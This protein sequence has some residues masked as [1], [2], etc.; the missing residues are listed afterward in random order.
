MN[1]E[2]LGSR[3]SKLK[4]RAQRWAG[5]IYKVIIKYDRH[6]H[7]IMTRLQSPAPLF[8]NSPV[9]LQALVWIAFLWIHQAHWSFLL[10]TFLAMI[11]VM[12]QITTRPKFEMWPVVLFWA[13]R[14]WPLAGRLACRPAIAVSWAHS[15]RANGRKAIHSPAYVFLGGASRPRPECASSTMIAIR[16]CVHLQM[17]NSWNCVVCLSWPAWTSSRAMQ[18]RGKKKVLELPSTVMIEF[19]GIGK[20]SSV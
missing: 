20:K 13:F 3:V 16:Q 10:F 15:P 9:V 1:N 19:Q 6:V 12:L 5:R 14:D 2:N 18:R 4:K 11:L 8:P 17:T 7:K